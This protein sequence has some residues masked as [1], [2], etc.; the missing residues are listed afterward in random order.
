LA[1]SKLP[2]IVIIDDTTEFLRELVDALRQLLPAQE[3][4]IREWAPSRD[5]ADPKAE[6]EARVDAGTVLVVTDYDLTGHGLT[7]L[8]GTAIVG[9]CQAKAL[10]VGDYSRANVGALPQEPNLFELRIPNQAHRAAP[11]IAA[12]FRGFHRIRTEMLAKAE[13]LREQRSPSAVLASLLAV[14]ELES[15]FTLYNIRGS[16]H[17]ALVDRITSTESVDIEPTD[18]E[19][20]VLLA[21]IVGHMLLNSVLRF[22]GPILSGEALCAYCASATAE[23]ETLAQFFGAAKYAGP[24]SEVDRFL[25]RKSVV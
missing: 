3:V 24:F 6:F 16:A 15:Q 5:K 20:A 14:P 7:G 19:K 25:D 12:V 2:S 18:T 11:V 13:S 17:A 23:T 8:F 10:P 21:Y 9:W 4:E 22:P 1:K